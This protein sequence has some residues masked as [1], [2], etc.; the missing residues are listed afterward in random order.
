LALPAA[1]AFAWALGGIVTTGDAS[2]AASLGELGSH[3]HDLSSFD[4]C[5][6]FSSLGFAF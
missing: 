4:P 2:A 1:L 6:S 5:L 3:G